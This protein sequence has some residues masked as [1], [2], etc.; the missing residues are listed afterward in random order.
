MNSVTLQDLSL[1]DYEVPDRIKPLREAYFSA[2][3]EVCAERPWF[4]TKYHVEHDLLAIDPATGLPKPISGLQKAR[5]YRHVLENRKAIIWPTCGRR[6]DGTVLK[7]EGRSLFAGSTTRKFKGVIVY[8]EFLGLTLWPEL[9]SISHRSQNPYYLDPGDRDCLNE[10]VFPHW[11]D[12]SLLEVTR[13]REPCPPRQPG[14]PM[15]DYELYQQMVFFLASKPNCLSHTIPDFSRAVREGLGAVK[16]EAEARAAASAEEAQRDF[17]NSMA[18]AL[19]GIIAYSRRLAEEA[20]RQASSETDASRRE[21]L[22]ALAEVHDRVPE[23][24]A[25]TFREALTAVWIC[26]VAAHLE[27]ANAALSLGRLDQLLYPYYQADLAAHRLDIAGALE[28]LCCFWLKIG[29]HVPLVP[30][31]GEQLFGGTG[32]NQAITIGGVDRAGQDAVNDLTYLMLRATELMM[33]RDPNLN[34]RYMSGTNPP[35]YLRRL[36]LANVRTGATPALHNDRAV[37][38]ALTAR[39]DPVEDARDYGVVGCVEPCSNGRHYGHSGAL[40]INL[41]SALELTLF[42]GRHRHT[43][44]E[45]TVGLATGDPRRFESFAEFREAFARQVGWLLDAAVRMN[46]RLGRTHQLHYP[47]PLLSAL[48]EGPMDS[49]KDLIYG[50]ARINS[51][52]VTIIGFADVVDSLSAIEEWVYRKG[53]I[54]LD[55]LI[56]VLT[57]EF[58]SEDEAEER[59]YEGLRELLRDPARTPKLG[60]ADAA[61]ANAEWLA[62][63]LDGILA[64]KKNYRCGAYRV[65]YWTMTN[66]A[67]LGR[68][69]G[70]MPNGRRKGENFASGLTP[71]SGATSHLTTTLNA[72]AAIPSRFVSSGMAVNIK[73]V[74]TSPLT[75]E[76]VIDAFAATVEGYFDPHPPDA[77]VPDPEAP[78]DR[79]GMEIQFNIIDPTTLMD[80]YQHPEDPQYQELLVRVSG[81]TAY[82]KDLNQQMQREI[83]ERSEYL[84]IDDAASRS[85]VF[86]LETEE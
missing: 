81:Y 49:G 14:E 69:V 80:A 70:A 16:Q 82:F 17:Y 77:A 65:G 48:F 45:D 78:D 26:F 13:R 36:C 39:G 52:G 20:R 42:N 5:A 59:E 63:L 46:E 79:R 61:R 68:L 75:R 12:Y 76:Q 55:K 33:L 11:L 62:G 74:P 23:H 34:A 67:G 4:I 51:S 25:R 60:E 29:D 30:E 19:E 86:P 32:S 15:N 37:I 72:I 28:L 43:G 6:H 47:T 27:N 85:F 7:I 71:V 35:E 8:P 40:L 84:L 3:P 31:T 57:A 21:E 54:S 56:T 24:P 64:A 50:G 73:F 9:H 58:R 38:R 53:Q 18:V 83:I 10:N 66:H 22:E 2:I 44:L 41:V 1:S